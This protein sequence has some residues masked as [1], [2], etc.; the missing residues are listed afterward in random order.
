MKHPDF[1]LPVRVTRTGKAKSECFIYST[2]QIQNKGIRYSQCD[3]VATRDLH[4]RIDN[5]CCG[6]YM[7]V[8]AV[9]N[10]YIISFNA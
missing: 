8:L 2:I 6:S 7:S 9:L 10:L 4:T 5:G 1:A 3:N